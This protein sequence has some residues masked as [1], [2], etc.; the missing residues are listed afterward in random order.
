[1]TGSAQQPERPLRILFSLLH[2]GYLRHYDEPIRI[3]A[4]RGHLVHIAVSRWEK[5]RGDD[6]LLR[7]LAASCPTVTYSLTPARRYLDG[8]RRTA[9][10]VRALMDLSRYGHPRF[11]DPS[12]LRARVRKKI[13]LRVGGRRFDPFNEWLMTRFIDRL[14]T[15][16]DVET[17]QRHVRFFARLEA[18]IPVSRRVKRLLLDVRPDVVLASPVVEIASEQVEIL[19][20]ARALGIPSGVCIASWDNLTNKGL[21][22]VLPDRVIVWNEWQR[23]ELAEFHDIPADRGIIT[24]AQKFDKWFELSTTTSLEEFCDKVGLRHAQPYLIYLCS[25]YFIAPDEVSFVRRWLTRVRASDSPELREIPVLVRPHPQNASQWRKVDLHEFGDVAIHPREG[26]QP[27]ANEAMTDFYDALSHSA[28]VVGVNSSALIEAAIVGK[29][30]YTVVD[31]V[32]AQTQEGTLHFHYLLEENGGFVHRAADLDVHTAQL[33]EALR[34][35]G[36]QEEGSQTRDF[37]ERFCRPKGLDRPAAPLVADAVEEVAR[38][39]VEPARATLGD[40]ALR[41]L[42]LP[43]PTTISVVAALT[44]AYRLTRTIVAVKVLRRRPPAYSPS[45]LADE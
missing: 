44:T 30:V 24:G 36:T 33:E 43:I 39:D 16:R 31:P 7:A 6:G 3:L 25:S 35:R 12:A 5:D 9:W 14:G 45:V 34:A 28:M 4:N 22:R 42:L 32:F 18:A 1:M 17:T 27:D 41:V 15:S 29:R 13:M 26:A 19:K 2:A 40:L 38:V 21:I 37:V 10:M 23:Q 20:S 11:A 8:W